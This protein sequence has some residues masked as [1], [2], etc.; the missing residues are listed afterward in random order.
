MQAAVVLAHGLGAS[1]VAEGVETADQRERLVALGCDSV[2]GHLLAPP[3]PAGEVTRL[4]GQL[5]TR[6]NV[7]R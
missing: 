6:R 4:L 2:Q 3:A 5:A 7:R 1:V